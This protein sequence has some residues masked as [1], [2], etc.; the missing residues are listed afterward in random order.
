[1]RRLD[2]DE[3]RD[4]AK[5]GKHFQTIGVHFRVSRTECE[6]GVNLLETSKRMVQNRDRTFNN[7]TVTKTVNVSGVN[8]VHSLTRFRARTIANDALTIHSLLIVKRMNKEFVCL[9]FF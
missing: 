5:S 7:G 4:L 9:F 8:N 1:M 3:T 6:I 2:V